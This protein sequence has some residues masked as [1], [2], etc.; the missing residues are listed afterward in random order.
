MFVKIV[1][2]S[3]LN[4]R[5]ASELERVWNTVVGQEEKDAFFNQL[6][7]SIQNVVKEFRL[8]QRRTSNV[9]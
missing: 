7:A 9:D 6:S 5:D 2:S 8:S 1:V 4:D 3:Q